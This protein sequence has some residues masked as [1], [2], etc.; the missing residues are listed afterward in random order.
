MSSCTK[1]EMLTPVAPSSE[2]TQESPTDAPGIYIETA[3]GVV[4][5]TG[6]RATASET[7]EWTS[8]DGIVRVS[9][10]GSYDIKKIE[11]SGIPVEFRV[12]NGYSLSRYAYRFEGSNEVTDEAQKEKDRV[13]RD[14][15]K[16]GKG[17]ET[18][19]G[20]TVAT[21]QISFFLPSGTYKG[22]VA[23]PEGIHQVLLRVEW[24]LPLPTSLID[25]MRKENSDPYSSI[26]YHSF[27]EEYKQIE[28]KWEDT[29]K[30]ER[31]TK[32]KFDTMVDP[33][34][35]SVKGASEDVADQMSNLEH[36]MSDLYDRDPDA[37]R[38]D[39]QT[40]ESD[41]AASATQ[42]RVYD[43]LLQKIEEWKGEVKRKLDKIM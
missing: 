10:L 4:H 31:P 41:M 9:G 28:A 24:K 40:Y 37:Y 32:E 2:A 36:G 38:D 1:R 3:D 34:I 33:L 14:S 35:N 43:S 25:Y 13:W 22:D 8:P 20:P 26:S 15:Y 27:I 42:I 29:W 39:V 30:R 21:D 6:L 17:L 23:I 12:R 16:V 11:E 18:F 19:F 5:N 7:R